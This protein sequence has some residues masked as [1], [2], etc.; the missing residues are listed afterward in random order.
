MNHMPNEHIGTL[1]ILDR[2]LW[3]YR[4]HWW[5][6]SGI[7]AALYL[8]WFCLMLAVSQLA[9]LALVAGYGW[10]IAST[11]FDVLNLPKLSDLLNAPILVVLMIVQEL[12]VFPI[13]CGALV[14]ATSTGDGQPKLGIWDTYRRIRGQIGPICMAAM[15]PVALWQL[16]LIAARTG[17]PAQLTMMAGFSAWGLANTTL[18]PIYLPLAAALGAGA[19]LFSLAVPAAVIDGLSAAQAWNRSMRLVTRHFWQVAGVTTIGALLTYILI[20]SVSI[21]MAVIGLYSIQF[22]VWHMLER[23]IIEL[24]WSQLAWIFAMPILTI[25]RAQLYLALASEEAPALPPR[26]PNPTRSAL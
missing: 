24:V 10:H 17:I 5:Q 20:R 13:I 21:L 6:A 23:F 1:R 26:V 7:V 11:H 16:A 19:L 8:P 14:A 22:L 15:L 12:A 2:A 9:P 4:A 18:H 3:R 25:A